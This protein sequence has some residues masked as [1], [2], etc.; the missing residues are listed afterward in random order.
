AR[1]G[2]QVMQQ[3][4]QQPQPLYPPQQPQSAQAP[5]PDSNAPSHAP[6][7]VPVQTDVNPALAQL[8]SSSCLTCHGAGKKPNRLDLRRLATM[9][10]GDRYYMLGLVEDGTMPQGREPI[11]N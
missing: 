5:P 9:S 7:G 11:S 3:S 6:G 8:V 4:Y 2:Q 1:P 10:V